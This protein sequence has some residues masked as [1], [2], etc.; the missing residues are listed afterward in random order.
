MREAPYD[1]DRRVFSGVDENGDVAGTHAVVV[2]RTDPV[3]RPNG[4]YTASVRLCVHFGMPVI[5]A[6]PLAS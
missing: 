1:T 4:P 6:N 5:R 3:G 2:G